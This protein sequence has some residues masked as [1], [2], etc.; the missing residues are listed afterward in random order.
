MKFIFV[1]FVGLHYDLGC[2]L[3]DWFEIRVSLLLLDQLIRYRPYEQEHK[4]LTREAE[5]SSVI[6]DI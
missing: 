2:Q 1:L 6:A 4:R 5:G 3:E